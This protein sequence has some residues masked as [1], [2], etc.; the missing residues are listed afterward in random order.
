MTIHFPSLQSEPSLRS[1]RRLSR[2][3]RH[4]DPRR[5]ADRAAR[6]GPRR[7]DGRCPQISRAAPRRRALLRDRLRPDR[8]EAAA[9][10][11][12]AP[13]RHWPAFIPGS[14]SGR[15]DAVPNQYARGGD[16]SHSRFESHDWTSRRNLFGNQTSAVAPRAGN[17]SCALATREARDV[18]ISHRRRRGLR[19]MLR[20]DRATPRAPGFGMPPEARTTRRQRTRVCANAEPARL[21]TRC[22]IRGL[23]GT[24]LYTAR[25]GHRRRRLQA[26]F[27]GRERARRGFSLA[28]VHIPA[29]ETAAVCH[30]PRAVGGSVLHNRR[31]GRNFLR[32]SRRR[33]QSSRCDFA[34]LA[35]RQC[36]RSVFGEWPKN[37]RNAR[38]KPLAVPYPAWCATSRTRTPPAAI[39]RRARNNRHARR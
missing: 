32:L 15:R 34:R 28:Y 33:G 5:R 39:C 14:L 38:L 22:R 29:R 20:P 25:V 12:T 1:R 13:Q 8:A 27:A 10:V 30:E 26:Y 16:R 31:R 23:P 37:L 21:A 11:G 24:E 9:R 6:S 35:L 4:C 19:A 2:A 18:W 7:Y 36:T 17:R 3:R